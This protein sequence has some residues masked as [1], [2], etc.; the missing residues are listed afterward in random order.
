MV[1]DGCRHS[2]ARTSRAA[3][4]PVR[5]RPAVVRHHVWDRGARGVMEQRARPVPQHRGMGPRGA[6]RLHGPDRGD[7]IPRARALGSH[8]SASCRA[9]GGRH[10]HGV[11][12]P[13]GECRVGDARV[14]RQDLRHSGDLRD[15][16]RHDRRHGRRRTRLGR[17]R[18]PRGQSAV[19]AGVI[20][21][22]HRRRR[23][24]LLHRTDIRPVVHYWALSVAS[25]SDIGGTMEVCRSYPTRSLRMPRPAPP[26][27]WLRCS[28][29]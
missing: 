23:R 12:R 11:A 28:P 15:L 21:R 1:R 26:G 8:A 4:P 5:R 3:G 9:P 29:T 14:D 25:M 13:R 16:H 27:V 18:L 22:V 6:H 7:R 19:A 10:L 20:A 2:R 24:H 17:R